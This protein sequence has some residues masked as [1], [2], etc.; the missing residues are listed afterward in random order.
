MKPQINKK[1][2][3]FESSP[4]FSDNSRGLWEYVKKNTDY[5]TFWVIKIKKC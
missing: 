4:D 2:M 5:E 3:V 1:L